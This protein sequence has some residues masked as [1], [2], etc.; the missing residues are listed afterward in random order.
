MESIEFSIEIAAPLER[1]RRE[2]WELADWPSVAPHVQAI[3][4][5]YEDGAVQVLTMRV[6]TG[7]RQDSF[8][9]VRILQAEAI[10][11]FQPQ[12]PPAL[13][14]HYGWWRLS[15]AGGA[16]TRVTSEH[17]IDVDPEPAARFLEAVGARMAGDE[18]VSAALRGILHHNSLQTM[19]ALKTR[20]EADNGGSHGLFPQAASRQA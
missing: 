19:L 12:P 5:H 9:S 11:F 10:F 2:F 14:R 15:A 7:Q 1:V 17:W 8:K 4:M 13:R 20:L 6:A 18:P 3:D 16:A